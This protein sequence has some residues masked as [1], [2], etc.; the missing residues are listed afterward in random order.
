MVQNEAI[1][2]GWK[3]PALRNTLPAAVAHPA[4]DA[5][6]GLSEEELLAVYGGG[7]VQAETTPICYTSVTVIPSSAACAGVG[8]GIVAGVTIV[9][10]IKRC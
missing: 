2:L 3:N 10:T 6:A 7:D 9:L 1:I 8:A 5:L 4:G